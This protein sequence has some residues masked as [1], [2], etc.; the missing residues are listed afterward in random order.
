[1]KLA[2]KSSTATIR[3]MK[4]RFCDAKGVAYCGSGRYCS[5]HTRFLRMRTDAK[6]KGK[7]VPSYD[8]L[9]ALVK[10]LKSFRCPICSVDMVWFRKESSTRVITL[11]HDHSGEF[12][13]ICFSCNTAHQF[14]PRDGF[15]KKSKHT[16]YCQ[17][18]KTFKP[19][20]EF[21][22]DKRLNDGVKTYCKGCAN[23]RTYVWRRRVKYK[24]QAWAGK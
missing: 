22:K 3:A 8:T 2:D 23:R 14:V 12:R 6:F 9:E 20:G 7:T 17:D 21:F 15:Y 4:C 16:R 24:G 18:C 1:M 10:A 13:L 11:Q 19:L 5:K